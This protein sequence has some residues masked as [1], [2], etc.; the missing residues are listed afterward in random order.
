MSLGSGWA[1]AG[2]QGVGLGQHWCQLPGSAVVGPS[3][4]WVLVAVCLCPRPLVALLGAGSWQVA[5]KAQNFR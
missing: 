5:N 3:A 2:N 4:C 1:V